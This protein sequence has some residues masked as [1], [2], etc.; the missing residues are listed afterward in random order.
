MNKKKD[1][2]LYTQLGIENKQLN[3]KYFENNA[4]FLECENMKREKN[5]HQ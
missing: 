2:I 5:V 3:T 1:N 4:N